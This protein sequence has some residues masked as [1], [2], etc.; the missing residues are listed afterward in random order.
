MKIRFIHPNPQDFID[1]LCEVNKL[2]D[3]HRMIREKE[4]LTVDYCIGTALTFRPYTDYVDPR[5]SFKT[6]YAIYLNKRHIGFADSVLSDLSI[7]FFSTP[8][9]SNADEMF[10]VDHTHIEHGC[11]WDAKIMRRRTIAEKKAGNKEPLMYC[12]C[13]AA[14]AEFVCNALN[15]S[16]LNELVKAAQRGQQ[17]P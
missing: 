3:L 17:L 10:Y 14:T 6:N 13:S 15:V 12:E 1:S 4:N 11:C 2:S 5:I 7:E 9:K 16:Y 8:A